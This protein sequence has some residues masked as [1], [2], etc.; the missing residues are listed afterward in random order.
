MENRI[1]KGFAR[2]Y[3][4]LRVH[5]PQL[6]ACGVIPANAGIQKPD[7]MPPDQSLPWNVSIQGPGQAYQ[8]RHDAQY[9]LAAEWFIG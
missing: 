2:L 6:A 8:V 1:G 5:S 7:W 9:P 3:G 4:S